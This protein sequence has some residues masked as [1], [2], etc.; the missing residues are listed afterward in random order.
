[1]QFQDQINFD[2]KDYLVASVNINICLRETVPI[3]QMY[4]V[5]LQIISEI[6]LKG[7]THFYC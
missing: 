2:F 7:K 5:L 3:C 6:I 4:Q 1:M